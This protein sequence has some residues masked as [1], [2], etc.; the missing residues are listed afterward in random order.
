MKLAYGGAAG[1]RSERTGVAGI[2]DRKLAAGN[3]LQDVEVVPRD[4]ARGRRLR[5]P[6]GRDREFGIVAEI[7]I[8]SAVVHAV[9][10]E[11]D[12]QQIVR[13]DLVAHLLRQL[14]DCPFPAGT[15]HLLIEEDGVGGEVVEPQRPPRERFADRTRVPHGEGQVRQPEFGEAIGVGV[16]IDATGQQIESGSPRLLLGHRRRLDRHFAQF[17]RPFC[18]GGKHL[19]EMV[20]LLGQWE[21]PRVDSA[22]RAAIGGRPL[23]DHA[24]F[25]GSHDA[26]GIG[27]DPGKG[28]SVRSIDFGGHDDRFSVRGG[29]WPW[30]ENPHLGGHG[31][32]LRQNDRRT[33]GQ[34][35]AGVT[36]GRV[37]A[38]RDKQSRHHIGSLQPPTKLLCLEKPGKFIETTVD[39]P[40]KERVSVGAGRVVAPRRPVRPF[41]IRGQMQR[42]DVLPGRQPLEYLLILVEPTRGKSHLGIPRHGRQGRHDRRGILV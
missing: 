25:A 11:E 4:A 15:G 36:E 31:N 19:H 42:G 30:I 22:A 16:A 24:G 40:A 34:L 9:A 27:R 26:A 18:R 33:F 5:I 37:E 28:R 12:H 29:P 1:R 7:G 32:L 8:L 21:I 41:A 39:Q 35:T 6:A 14:L 13:N 23:F 2:D 10:R 38:P 20:L 17:G 3:P